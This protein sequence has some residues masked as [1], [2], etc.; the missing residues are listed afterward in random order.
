MLDTPFGIADL[1]SDKS[2]SADKSN[3]AVL[4]SDRARVTPARRFAVGLE[5]GQAV[6]VILAGIAAKLI[7]LDLILGPPQAMLP[8]LALTIPLAV[9]LHF[10][11]KQ[12]R[13]HEIDTLAGPTIRFGSIWG[14]LILSFLVLL[15]GMYLIKVADYYSRGWLLCWF[16]LSAVALVTVRWA[17]MKYLKTSLQTGRLFRRIALYGTPAYVTTL[18]FH[19][20]R[21]FPDAVVT[22]IYINEGDQEAEAPAGECKSLRDL[23][24]AMASGRYEK[25]IIGMPASE[26]GRIRATVKGLGSYAPEIML[27]TNLEAFPLPLHGSRAIGRLRAEIVSPV[28]EAEQNRFQKR[29]LDCTLAAA[30]LTILAPLLALTALAIKLD[31][32]GPVFFRQR[33][34]GRNNRVFR[35]F[36]FRTMS[37]AEDGDAVMQAEKSDQRVT[38]VGR[39]LRAASVDELPQLINVLFGQ[40]SVVGPRPH[41]LVHEEKFEQSSDLFSR[42]RRVLPGITGWAQ[43]NG[44]RGETKTQSDVA[45]RLEYDLYYIDNWSIWFD[46]E[47]IARTMVTVLRGAY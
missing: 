2:K 9:A 22:G 46:V 29:L 3:S 24:N 20:E 14:G 17:T 7:Y 31:S 4:I 37:V 13:L 34:Y 18:K 21:E 32:P 30:G 6:T 1:T 23:Q 43:V 38:R 8:Y 15:G 41:A 10:F 27:C 47:I 36:K 25:I 16:A 19:V 12:M 33:R 39:F 11:F 44:C 42:R 26:I 28:P 35:I 45:R 40:M 5:I